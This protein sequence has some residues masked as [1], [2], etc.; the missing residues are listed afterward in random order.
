MNGCNKVNM[1]RLKFVIVKL[2]WAL[3]KTSQKTFRDVLVIYLYLIKYLNS[4]SSSLLNDRAFLTSKSF[5]FN[6]TE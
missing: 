5:W 1:A 4:F 6:C 2:C 3:I